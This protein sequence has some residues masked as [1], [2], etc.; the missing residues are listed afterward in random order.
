MKLPGYGR[1]AA[2]AKAEAQKLL[3]V[4]GVTS[5]NF[6]LLN[7]SGTDPS[8]TAGVYLLDQWRRIGVT[9]QHEQFE[10][11]QYQTALSSGSF[12][13]D[14]PAIEFI[15]DYTDDPTAQF[16]K[17][18]SRKVSA[19]GYSNHTDNKIMTSIS[20]SVAL[21]ILSPGARS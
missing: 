1:D 18:L 6:K 21:S 15:S 8:T 13:F 14:A 11:T 4:A 5:L 20:G 12:F 10:T 9:A 19:V 2:A 7:R 16:T 3:A 17:F